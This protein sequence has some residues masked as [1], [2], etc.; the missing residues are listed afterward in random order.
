MSTVEAGSKDTTGWAPAAVQSGVQS[1]AQSAVMC[2]SSCL[3]HLEGGWQQAHLPL[4]PAG[5]C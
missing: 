3:V 1:G 5:C 2:I 4:L